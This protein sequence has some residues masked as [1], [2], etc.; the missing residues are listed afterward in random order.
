MSYYKKQTGFGQISLISIVLFL[1]IVT[2]FGFK[3]YNDWE[4]KKELKAENQIIR[5]EL[6]RQAK[7]VN[8]LSRSAQISQQ[9]L[10]VV[11]EKSDAA[12]QR[13]LKLEKLL[14]QMALEEMAVI[15]P[16]GTEL[17]INEITRKQFED[18]ERI[19]QK[20]WSPITPSLDEPK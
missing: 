16:E 14:E 10:G 2:G 9:G 1:A 17:L 12:I 13:S 19:T 11:E 20:D 7:E 6:Q 3:L 8:E 18:L 5:S 4:S 15:D